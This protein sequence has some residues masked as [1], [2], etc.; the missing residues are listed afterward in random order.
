MQNVSSSLSGEKRCEA[1]RRPAGGRAARRVP[2]H[3]RPTACLMVPEFSRAVREGSISTTRLATLG[4]VNDLS[5]ISSASGALCTP[6]SQ[7]ARSHFHRELALMLPFSAC[8]GFR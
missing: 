3:A 8:T 5:L 6:L 4:I 7:S 2:S 1:A